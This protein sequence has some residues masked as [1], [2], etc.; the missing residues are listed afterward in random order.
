MDRPR[1][2]LP[3]SVVTVMY[4]SAHCVARALSSVPDALERIVVDNASADRSCD[5]ATPLASLLI[6][7]ARNVGFGAAC[8][9]GAL[10][11][12]GEFLLFLNPDAI[13]APDAL[14]RL[15]A[16]ARQCPDAVAF[17]ARG[18][19]PDA[20]DIDTDDLDQLRHA[21]R[22]QRASGTQAA[23][24][25]AAKITGVAL[26]CRASTFRDVGG[27]DE[28]F[29][30]YFEDEDL[31]R[32]L[33]ER[34]RLMLVEEAVCYHLP[35]TGAR[36]TPRQRFVKYRHY[37]HSRVRFGRKHGTGFRPLGAAIEQAAKGILALLT[38]DM[39]RSAQHFG[40]AVGYVEGE[41]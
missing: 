15:V 33:A 29:F 3:V 18:E 37:G 19:L 9:T 34:G 13:L 10:R 32:R 2:L 1:D 30:L 12:H 28:N 6:R 20:G 39:P 21:E 7:N 41:G 5:V 14:A 26:M 23:G 36:L 35:G 25:G 16:A 24:R 8:N 31:C 27:F 11:A 40:R 22:K 38:A 17:G 4:N